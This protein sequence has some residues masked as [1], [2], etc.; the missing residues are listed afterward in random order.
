MELEAQT[1]VDISLLVAVAVTQAP[2]IVLKVPSGHAY[3][4]G[5]NCLDQNWAVFCSTE[6]ARDPSLF[7]FRVI[8]L[9]RGDTL[10]Y[11]GIK[12]GRD[13]QQDEAIHPCTRHPGY[14]TCFRQFKD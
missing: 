1:M 12:E 8:I 6:L 2:L 10:G 3:T 11:V 5:N 9:T 4:V 14:A 13:E 7:L